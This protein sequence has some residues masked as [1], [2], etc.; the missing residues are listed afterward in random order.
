[1][2]ILFCLRLRCHTFEKNNPVLGILSDSTSLGS[3]TNGQP[4]LHS[5]VSYRL[6][7][8]LFLLQPDIKEETMWRID[9][10]DWSDL[11]VISTQLMRAIASNSRLERKLDQCLWLQK[12]LMILVSFLTAICFSTFYM[13]YTGER[14]PWPASPSR[15][16]SSKLPP[17][18]KRSS[19]AMQRE[20]CSSQLPFPAVKAKERHTFMWSPISV[21]ESD[22]QDLKENNVFLLI[23]IKSCHYLLP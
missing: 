7:L 8:L 11:T 15:I 18:Q 10:S 23:T 4:D 19:H 14:T 17:S 22:T 2:K 1:M 5:T 9:L 12:V 6:N 3:G 16:L 20:T 21:S 13:L